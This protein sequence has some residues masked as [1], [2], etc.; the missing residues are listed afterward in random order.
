LSCVE[1]PKIIQEA[2]NAPKWKE[3]ILKKMRALEKNH[4]WSVMPLLTGK[5]I[6]GCKWLFTVKYNSDGS[7]ERYKA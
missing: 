5:N 1:V 2:L 3:A 6:V 7:V 4:T